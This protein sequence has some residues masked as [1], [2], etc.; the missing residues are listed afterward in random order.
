MTNKERNEL[1][2]NKLR[3]EL[4]IK[5]TLM[6]FKRS[7]LSYISTACVFVSLALT[8]LKLAVPSGIDFYAIAMFCVGLAFLAFGVIEYII[9]KREAKHILQKFETELEQEEQELSGD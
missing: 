3:T 7:L 1:K 2:M 8:Y 6:S 4:S 5:R 9:N